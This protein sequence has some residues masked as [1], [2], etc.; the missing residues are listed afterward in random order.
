MHKLY[1][2]CLACEL[3]MPVITSRFIVTQNVSVISFILIIFV[4]K[5]LLYHMLLVYGML[6]F[7]WNLIWTPIV[8][9]L[10]GLSNYRMFNTYFLFQKTLSV[11]S[12]SNRISSFILTV[13]GNEQCNPAHTITTSSFFI[14]QLLLLILYCCHSLTVRVFLLVYLLLIFRNLVLSPPVCIYVPRFYAKVAPSF[15]FCKII[16]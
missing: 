10:N 1:K 15:H 9:I 7:C 8:L 14:E 6:D 16:L 13:F 11:E 12:L 5:F 3:T 2:S 4:M